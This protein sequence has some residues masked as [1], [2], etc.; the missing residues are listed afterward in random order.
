MSARHGDRDFYRWDYPV[1]F[2]KKFAIIFLLLLM[3]ISTANAMELYNASDW[4]IRWDNTLKGSVAYRLESQ[5]EDLIDAAH[6]NGD[7]GDRNFDRG[8]SSTRLDLLSELDIKRLNFGVHASAAGWVDG[9]YLKSNDNNSPSTFNGLGPNNEFDDE[10][11][12]LHGKKIELL[13]AF[14][15]GQFNIGDMSASF[16]LGRHTLLWGETLFFA[17]N[18]IANGMAPID[19]IKGLG[20]PSTPAK[21]IFMPVNQ[22]SGQLQIMPT[23]AFAGFVGLEWRRTRIPGSGSYFSSHDLLDAGGQRLF[24]GPSAAGPALW[25]GEDMGAGDS[26]S[27]FGDSGFESF[28]ASMRFRVPKVDADW[29]LYY[30]QYND[31]VPQIYLYPGQNV[32]LAVGKVGEY[33]LV[34]PKNIQ[35][36]GASFGTE[37]GSVNVSGEVSER[38]DTPLVSTPQ[39]VLPGMVA[40]NDDHPLYA[41]GNTLHANVSLV[42][43]AAAGPSLGG[44]RLWDG[45]TIMAEVGYTYLV[46]ITENESAFDPTRDDYAFGIRMTFEPAYYQVVSGLD[47]TVPI[48]VGYNPAGKSPVD[49]QFNVTG[50]DEGGDFSVGIAGI[51]H[52]NWRTGITYTNYFGSTDTQALADRDF[53]SVYV[54]RTF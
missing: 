38:L 20:V 39:V 27:E 31:T 5:D 53:V 28:G 29:G 9:M 14:A 47:L 25:R 35:M 13:D 52:S 41:I 18:G 49:P 54:Q 26:T 32:N 12:Q 4:A 8:F 46:D 2:L 44:F 23:L 6:V 51:Y 33:A 7:D 50:A 30:H 43:L 40:D 36:I 3:T 21:E 42:Y 45:A 16:R 15:F 24:L 19:S 48:G 1:R 34:Y 37:I 22:V 17:T 11:E 10:T